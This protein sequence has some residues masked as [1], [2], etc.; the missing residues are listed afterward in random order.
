MFCHDDHPNKELIAVKRWVKVEIEGPPEH[1]F[2]D[3][4]K[5]QAD[6]ENKEEQAT[7]KESLFH[8]GNQLEDI[9]LVQ[10][11]GLNVDDDNDP[12]DDNIPQ[13]IPQNNQQD[14]DPDQ[15]EQIGWGWT[16]I[17]H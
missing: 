3:D 12:L 16:G 17:D 10:A 14:N 13:N 8:F 2:R 5:E 4:N 15:H 11:M 7:I 1:Y 6:N 9:A